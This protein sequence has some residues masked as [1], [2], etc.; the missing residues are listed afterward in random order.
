MPKSA[1]PS[2]AEDSILPPAPSGS[3]A[4]EALYRAALG[5]AHAEHYL[6]VFAHFDER[7]VSGPAWNTAAAVGNLGW[8]VYRQLWGAAGEF[9]AALAVWALIAAG[10]AFWA[11]FLPMGVRVGLALALLLLLLIVP[12]LYGTALLH[13][14]ACQRMIAVVRRAATMEEACTLLRR[15]GDAHRRRCAKGMAGLLLAVLL[16]GGVWMVWPTQSV[17]PPVVSVPI[18]AADL[19]PAEPS[20]ASASAPVEAPIEAPPP[21]MGTAPAT[22]VEPPPAPGVAAPTAETRAA[23]VSQTVA[24]P[25]ARSSPAAVTDPPVTGVT[26]R[27][28]GHGVSVGLFALPVNA[29]RAQA[30]L[31][32]AGLPVLK[33]PIESAR[34]TLMRVRVGPF[35][36]PEQAQAAAERVLALGFDARLYAP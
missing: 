6:P 32:A 21:A 14:Q 10:L 15:Q 24:P 5:P 20:L 30:R 29:E 28:Q 23:P 12:G 25:D 35:E 17:S 27:I 18:P 2:D 11:D 1:M 13:A 16:A 31:A 19:A 4:K 8:L 7:G 26:V 3:S 36:R 22:P 33:D 9:A 34:G